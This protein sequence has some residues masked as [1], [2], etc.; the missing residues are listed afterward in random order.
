MRSKFSGKT[1]LQCSY[2][3]LGHTKLITC[4]SDPA[5][6]I[7]SNSVKKYN[8]VSRVPVPAPQIRRYST[9]KSI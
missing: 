6:P 2:C 3:Y 7:L 9:G 5:G 4:F 1:L 8:A